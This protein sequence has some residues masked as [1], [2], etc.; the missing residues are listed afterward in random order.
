MSRN[1]SSC[2]SLH[3][4]ARYVCLYFHRFHSLLLIGCRFFEPHHEPLL[5]LAVG[6]MH[7]RRGGILVRL[8]MPVSMIGR[9]LP[10]TVQASTLRLFVGHA[11]DGLSAIGGRV[12]K[13]AADDPF[14]ADCQLQEQGRIRTG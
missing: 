11:F 1:L 3:A 6:E 2:R 14:L 10:T 9:V 12:V 5:S 4:G 8:A 7:Q 13:C